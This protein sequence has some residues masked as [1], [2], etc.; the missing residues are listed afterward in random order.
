M[1]R[2]TVQNSS[3]LIDLVRRNHS[4]DFVTT[5][6]RFSEK[7]DHPFSHVFILG[8]MLPES[9]GFVAMPVTSCIKDTCSDLSHLISEGRQNCS[10]L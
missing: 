4:S 9:H 2:N 10:S 1:E 5:T 7:F 3:K 6:V 8:N